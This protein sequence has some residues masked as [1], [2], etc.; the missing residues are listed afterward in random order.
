MES[1][2]MHR[3]Y[4]NAMRCLP[5]DK[6]YQFMDMLI[7]YALD[8]VEPVNDPMFTPM[9]Q[10]IKP[11]ID[12]SNR[13]RNT[14]NEIKKLRKH[15]YQPQ[16]TAQETAQDTAQATT[17]RNGS[18]SGSGNGNKSGSGN[19]KGGVEGVSLQKPPVSS[20]SSKRFSPPSVE[21]VEAYCRERGNGVNAQK[22]V[23]HYAAC[24][25]MIGKN[26]MKDW[27]AAVRT[28]EQRDKERLDGVEQSQ[29]SQWDPS[30]RTL[31]P[32]RPADVD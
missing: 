20:E 11:N 31:K 18:G 19:G 3:S 10:L 25:W 1:F 4:V 2:T 32:R 8:G 17:H 29:G 23:D 22:F 15:P 9:F 24:G 26:R 21:E 7:N 16:D 30:Q 5:A 28:W 14:M 12:E 27:R 6:Q 13:K